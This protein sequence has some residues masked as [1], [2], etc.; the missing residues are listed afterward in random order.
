MPALIDSNVIKTP[1]CSPS[2]TSISQSQLIRKPVYL[3]LNHI[4][5]FKLTHHQF[6][7]ATEY[8]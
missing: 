4:A 2:L 3:A 1:F 8:C 7:S 5:S 6:L